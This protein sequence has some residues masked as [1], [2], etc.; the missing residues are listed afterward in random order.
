MNKGLVP[1]GTLKEE[2]RRK[3]VGKTIN[4]VEMELVHWGINSLEKNDKRKGSQK[5]ES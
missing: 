5:A 3:V 4:L 2:P 1:R